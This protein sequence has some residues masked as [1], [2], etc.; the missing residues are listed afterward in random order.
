MGTRV[1]RKAIRG[2]DDRYLEL[3]RTFPLRPIRAD[4]DLDRAIEIIDSLIDRDDLDEGEADYLDVLGD[5]VHRYEDKHL[6]I[7]EFSDADMLRFLLRV[8]A[9][10]PD[11]TRPAKRCRRVNDFGDPGTETDAEPAPYLGAFHGS[12]A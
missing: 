5:L 4:A 12:S 7:Q 2:N 8:E 3:V 6:P 9:D 10:Q 11:R 1:K